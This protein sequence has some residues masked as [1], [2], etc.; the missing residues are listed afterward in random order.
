MKNY[1]DKHSFEETRETMFPAMQ[2]VEKVHPVFA[3]SNRMRQTLSGLQK[4]HKIITGIEKMRHAIIKSK[5]QDFSKIEGSKGVYRILS[6]IGHHAGAQAASKGRKIGA[7]SVYTANNKVY[8][9]YPD[10][11]EEEISSAEANS[12]GTYYVKYVPGTIR[13][14]RKK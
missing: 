5:F 14:A 3:S 12:L 4:M 2:N 9:V 6:H 11:K 13:Y 1:Q 7:A 8:K 10:G